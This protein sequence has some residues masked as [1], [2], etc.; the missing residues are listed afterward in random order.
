MVDLNSCGGGRKGGRRESAL[1]WQRLGCRLCKVLLFWM[2]L[3]LGALDYISVEKMPL[4]EGPQ[5][6]A[7][8]IGRERGL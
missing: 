5:I 7:G 4:S 6:I 2:R 8:P 1:C 3:L